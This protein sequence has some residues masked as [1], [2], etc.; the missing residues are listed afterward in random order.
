MGR[1]YFGES[2]AGDMVAVKV[3]K[4]TITSMFTDEDRERFAKEVDMMKRVYGP[5]VA[6][7]RDADPDGDPPWL[8]M[9]F[10]PG[11]SLHDHVADHAP[12]PVELVASLG[13]LLAEGIGTIHQAGLL[14]R[15]L[16]P[17][18]IMLGPNGP[19]IIDFG[20]ATL[21]E[22]KRGRITKAGQALGTPLFMAPEQ[23]LGTEK[24]TAATDVHALAS[25]LLYAATR[26]YPYWA[27]SE[28]AVVHKIAQADVP[29][30]LSAAPA[31]LRPLLEG[32][33]AHQPGD[34]PSMTQ[35]VTALGAVLDGHGFAPGKARTALIQATARGLHDPEP[36]Y[37]APPPEALAPPVDETP[38][39]MGSEPGPSPGPPPPA[40]R[41]KP[42]PGP[43]AGDAT[44][45]TVPDLHDRE[46]TVPAAPPPAATDHEPGPTEP[47]PASPA[48]DTPPQ[49]SS[50]PRSPRPSI[51][52]GARRVAQRLRDHYAREARF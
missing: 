34:R 22:R 26:T 21:A 17:Q 25:C 2:P 24:L 48:A 13:A 47:L 50:P 6:S 7:L 31:E 9:V 40:P 45:P 12:L 14:H 49:R 23:V 1:V 19:M 28:F 35:V 33:L 38:S 52:A 37:P 41:T 51:P 11:L 20:L 46:P 18:N 30:D 4:S 29:P 36:T 3:I 10:V 16:K 32:M 44:P 43:G 8:A 27:P 42:F 5:R 15:D 39:S